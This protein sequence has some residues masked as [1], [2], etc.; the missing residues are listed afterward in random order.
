MTIITILLSYFLTA[1]H[2]NIVKA[3][4]RKMPNSIKQG[5]DL[6]IGNMMS[7]LGGYFKAQF[8]IMCFVF[9]ILLVG[10]L[11]LGVDYAVLFALII[12]GC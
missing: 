9:I 2:D 10:L 6:I 12:A 7:A 4:S 8:K 1:E 3:V 5:Y 11:I